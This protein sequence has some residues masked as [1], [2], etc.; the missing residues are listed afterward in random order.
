MPLDT[1]LKRLEGFLHAE[2][3][4]VQSKPD[5]AIRPRLEIE[6]SEALAQLGVELDAYRAALAGGGLFRRVL[7]G[8]D[9]CIVELGR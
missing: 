3:S 2:Q 6:R 4:W 5:D 1:L 9:D 7:V 8:V